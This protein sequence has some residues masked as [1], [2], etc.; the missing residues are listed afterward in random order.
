MRVLIAAGA[1]VSAPSRN[2]MRVTALHSAIAGR[3]RE[4]ALALIAAGA[5]V[6]AKQQDD[7]TALHEAAQNGDREIVDALL[8]AGAD[9]SLTLG[10]GERV[11][12]RLQETSRWAEVNP[13]ET[14]LVAANHHDLAFSGHGYHHGEVGQDDP[15]E[16][17]HRA[18]Q[19]PPSYLRDSK[20]S[21]NRLVLGQ[22]ASP[23][24]VTRS[25][26]TR[27]RLPRASSARN[28]TR[29]RRMSTPRGAA[30]LSKGVTFRI[31]DADRSLGPRR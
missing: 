25:P 31:S 17:V 19:A 1:D 12:A 14:M 22:V 7:F 8:A 20:G 28:L 3:D 18:F 4:S 27:R 11:F 29:C 9:A 13:P 26:A 6:N 30:P 15:V 16:I 10:S 2:R 24:S 21:T 23:C 5:D